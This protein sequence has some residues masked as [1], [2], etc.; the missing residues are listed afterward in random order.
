[1]VCFSGPK[2]KFKAGFRQDLV[3]DFNFMKAN[4]TSCEFQ[5]LDGRPRKRFLGTEEG[6]DPEVPSGHFANEVNVMAMQF[7]D[8]EKRKIKQANE[9]KCI[10]MSLGI[11]LC[12]PTVSLDGGSGV[13][14]ALIAF[15][16]FIGGDGHEMAIYDAGWSEWVRKA[17]ELI[18]TG[19]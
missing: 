2:T 15:I 12:K 14:A 6:P 3:K 16:A 4:I 1:M 9:I 18:L 7:F 8:K 10:M 17:P 19:N 5:V 13:A 11:D